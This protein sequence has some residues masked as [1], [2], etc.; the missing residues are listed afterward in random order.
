MTRLMP[1]TDRELELWNAFLPARGLDARAALVANY[2][3]FVGVTARRLKSHIKF[4]ELDDLLSDGQ[5]GLMTA[6]DAFRLEWRTKFT[7]YASPRVRGAMLDG[8]RQRDL[9]TKTGRTWQRRIDQAHA[10]ATGKLHAPVNASEVAGEL[11]VSDKTLAALHRAFCLTTQSLSGPVME[12]ST[13]KLIDLASLLPD[14]R[15]AEP[16]GDLQRQMLWREIVSLCDHAECR[17]LEM[18]YHEDRTFESIAAELGLSTAGA[19]AAHKVVIGKLR[20]AFRDRA[21]E[22]V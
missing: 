7:S 16:G 20:R 13:G 3:P 18:R 12:Q 15:A 1:L 9:L 11:G 8:V 6:I 2:Q 4:A 22:F 17:I 19:W 21:D 14:R 5:L 10:T